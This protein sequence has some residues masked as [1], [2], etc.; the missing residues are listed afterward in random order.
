MQK[1]TKVLLGIATL[2]PLLYIF[3]FFVFVFTMA[4][5]LRGG[6]QAEP[7]IQP[8]MAL[9]L[10]LHLLTMVI[11]M[12]LTV[13]YIVDVF[14]NERVDK[15][16]KALWAIVI[17]MGNAIAMPIYW[18]LYFWK[19][20]STRAQVFPDQ[21]NQVNTAAWT[22]EARGSRQEQQQY[23]PPPQPPNWRE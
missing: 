3:L 10:G 6:A 11:I 23:A 17:F 2:W 16:K 9:V 5:G 4:F 12:A 14:R 19:E 21:L 15:D 13:F 7:G 8:A 18:Y 22:N 20:P 1:S